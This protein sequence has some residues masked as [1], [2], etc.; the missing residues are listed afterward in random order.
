MQGTGSVANNTCFERTSTTTRVS[1]INSSSTRTGGL[2]LGV[3]EA[4]SPGILGHRQSAVQRCAANCAKSGRDRVVRGTLF[5]CG[6][7][8]CSPP[9]TCGG[10]KTAAESRS[11]G[12]PRKL[13]PPWSGPGRAENE[14]K[15]GVALHPAL[16]VTPAIEA[17][18]QLDIAYI[19]LQYY[20]AH[21]AFGLGRWEYVVA[22]RL[23]MQCSRT[24]LH[25]RSLVLFFC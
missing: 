10:T 21:A 13:M 8:P 24:N 11:R 1:G 5:R 19:R 2:L 14:R 16:E 15:H 9:V 23:P 4:F 22:S 6:V 18:E 20:G 3:P 7:A 25:L 12:T 17:L